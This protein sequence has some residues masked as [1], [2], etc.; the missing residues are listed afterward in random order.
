MKFPGFCRPSYTPR[1]IIAD[2][3]RTV[4]WNIEVCESPM[5]QSQYTLYRTPGTSTFINTGVNA[6]RGGI[7]LNGR[8]FVIFNTTLFEILSNG[9]AVALGTVLNDTLLAAFAI[10]P[11][12]LMWC[13]RVTA[14][15]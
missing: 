5:A 13:R 3:E 8:C 6:F 15:S 12:Q 2:S 10:N 4:N 11:T 14:T 7:A 1:S 9:T